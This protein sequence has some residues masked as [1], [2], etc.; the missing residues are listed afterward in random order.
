MMSRYF[1]VLL[2]TVLPLVVAAG[3]SAAEFE[4]PARQP[5]LWDVK[6]VMGPDLPPMSMQM[7]L[8]E[9]SDRQMMQQGMAMSEGMCSEISTHREGDGF[10]VES[11]CNIEGGVTRTR[12]TITGDFQSAYRM[13]I[14]SDREGGNASI[15]KHTEMTH[16]GTHQGACGKN[17]VPGD[18]IVMGRKMNILKMRGGG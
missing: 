11:T 6:I 13:D 17:M 14:V 1:K 3:L 8:D 7:C 18:I 12:A 10:V 9:T 15:P 2:S 16:E 4:L 5:G